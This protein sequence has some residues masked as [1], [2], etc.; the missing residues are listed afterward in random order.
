V[1]SALVRIRRAL[2]RQST[3]RQIASALMTLLVLAGVVGGMEASGRQYSSLM[4]EQ[5]QVEQFTIQF[6]CKPYPTQPDGLLGF[7]MLSNQR[8]LIRTPDYTFLFETDSEGFPNRDPWPKDPKVVFLGD[9]MILGTGVG[10]DASFP[11]LF[12]GRPP[13]QPMV[14][15]GLAAAGPERQARAYA[16]YGATWHPEIVV[17]CLFLTSDFD[18][19]FHFLSWIQD[20]Q[21]RDYDTYRIRLARARNRKGRFQRLL[22]S[23]VVLHRAFDPILGLIEGPRHPKGHVRLEDG[24]DL[25]LD[26]RA[27]QFAATAAAPDDPRVRLLSG[28][29][30]RLRASVEQSGAE[31]VVM[32]IPS[33]EELFGIDA[34]QATA[35]LS[36]RFKQRLAAMSLPLIDLYPRL[37]KEGAKQAVYFPHDIHL[38]ALG[39][40]IV[41]EELTAWFRR[42]RSLPVQ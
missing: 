31:L 4:P 21:P 26:R 42:R 11:A 17:S 7:R 36:S 23:S 25:L 27:F 1:R 8:K 35:N 20:D 15:L 3:R 10:L 6:C 5:W 33:K 38:N 14:N 19:D 29:V 34:A 28:S 22:D 9:S 40:K 13:Q 30:A 12:A 24:S 41:A 16:R 37:Q 32:L 2:N 18:N 39:N